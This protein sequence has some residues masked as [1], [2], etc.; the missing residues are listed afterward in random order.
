MTTERKLIAEF[1]GYIEVGDAEYFVHPETNYDHS[2]YSSE[3][4]LYNKSWD[5]LMPVVQKIKDNQIFGSQKLIDNIDN[6]LT[7]DC[8]IENVYAEVVKFIDWYNNNNP[9]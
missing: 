2:I 1:M 7:V 8:E 4:F 9:N 6:A 3:W 5:W